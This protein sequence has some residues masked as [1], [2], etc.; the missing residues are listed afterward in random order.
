MSDEVSHSAPEITVP[1]QDIEALKSELKE[2]KD[3]YLRSLAESENSRKR[4]QKERL[5]AIQYATEGLISDFLHPLDS[6]ENALKFTE[7]MPPEVKNWA[8]GFQ[9]ILNQFKDIL[10]SHGVSSEPSLNQEF[11]PHKHEAIE[12]IETDD[13]APGTILQEFSKGYKMGSRIIRPAKVKV[14]KA[15]ED[16]NIKDDL[17]SIKE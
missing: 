15:K 12:I 11:D 4:L 9:M 3:K 14:A 7:Q 10:T 2:L 6:F 13:H 8:I 17:E 1:P 16:L 5:E